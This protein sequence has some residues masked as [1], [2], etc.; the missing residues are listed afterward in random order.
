MS[1]GA[2]NHTDNG[3]NTSPQHTADTEA[4]TSNSMQ[5][6]QTDIQTPLISNG[7]EKEHKQTNGDAKKETEAIED[8]P[9]DKSGVTSL[10]NLVVIAPDGGWGWVV[11]FA[12]FVCQAIIEGLLCVFGQILPDLLEVYG[13]GRGTTALAGSLMPGMFLMSGQ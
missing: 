7:V 3:R 1:N 4:V 13:A 6:N 11:V 5:H 8:I 2:A 10:K 9:E 12:S